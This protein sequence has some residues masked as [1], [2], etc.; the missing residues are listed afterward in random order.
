MHHKYNNDRMI[1]I[2][3]PSEKNKGKGIEHLQKTK[4]LECQ[5]LSQNKTSFVLVEI[6]KGIR[7]QIRAHLAAIGH[8]ICGDKLYSKSKHTG[9]QNLQLYSVGIEIK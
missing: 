7:H 6:Q 3:N 9:Y 8:P 1:V 4:I 5:F 2:Q